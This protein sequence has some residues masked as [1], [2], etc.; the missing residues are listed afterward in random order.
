V[1][2]HFR[3]P[4]FHGKRLHLGVTGS[5]AAFKSLT[6][7]RHF[8]ETG[9]SVSV[10]L[11]Q[12]ATQFVTAL[13]FQ[14]LGADPVYDAFFSKAE[15]PFDHLEPAR[16]AQC[17]LIAP[18]TANFISKMARGAADDLLSCQALAF[19]KHQIVAPA[20]NP[21]LWNA[22][23]TRENIEILS[24][25]GVE[26]LEPCSGHMACGD[27]GQ[28][29]LAD[30]EA[31]FLSVL[32]AISPQDLAGR[33]VLVSLG[34]THEYFDV[35]RYW[36][37][38][39]S[40]LM[41]ACIALAAWLRGARVQVV[42]GPVEWYFPPGVVRVPVVSA[43]QM[44]DA[45]NDLFPT[46]DVTCM[47]AAVADFSP[48]PH[49]SPTKKV[50]RDVSGMTTPDIRFAP[51]PDILASLGERKTAQQCLM[52]FCA[53]TGDLRPLAEEKLRRKKCDI[54][55]A[56][57]LGQSGSGFAASTNAV[58]VLDA[59]GRFETWP[60]LPKPEVAWRLLDWANHV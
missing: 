16:S 18:A 36:S 7:L 39:S 28:G 6:L 19:A 34:P 13:S 45:M 57:P 42:H 11:T 35:A 1:H 59:H 9:L 46:H 56:N 10:T 55:V 49:G 22:A 29:R 30:L 52:G 3:F 40:G 14:S 12:A 48:V 25:R 5:I 26:V 23:A 33:S 41:G 20:M 58:S 17:Q 54:M 50:K 21:L 44:H 2:P 60:V 51:N 53:E 8:L 4:F 43:R 27:S 15:S 31:L 24:K 32:R 37:N 38:P 47:V